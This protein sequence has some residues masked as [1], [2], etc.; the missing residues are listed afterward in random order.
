VNEAGFC[1][2]FSGLFTTISGLQ[3][4]MSQTNAV[5]KLPNAVFALLLLFWGC[6]GPQTNPEPTIPTAKNLTGTWRFYEEGYSPGAG[7]IVNPIPATP[8]QTLTFLADGRLQKQG[9]RLTG[10]F[11]APYY[12]VDSTAT[13]R[14]VYFLNSPQATATNSMLIQI[15]GDTLRLSPQCFEGCHFGFVRLR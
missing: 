6:A 15:R 1:D 5:M 3:W 4:S 9:D 7:Y 2:D 8:P 13:G 10:S 14:R 11:A 12:R